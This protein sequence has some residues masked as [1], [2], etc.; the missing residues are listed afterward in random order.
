MIPAEIVRALVDEWLEDFD[1]PEAGYQAMDAN[2]GLTADAWRKRL[3]ETTTIGGYSRVDGEPIWTVGWWARE[4]LDPGDV[5]D[6]LVAM[7]A[8]H[9]WFLPPLHDLEIDWA[10]AKA[11][12][13]PPK[14]KRQR[15]RGFIPPENIYRGGSRPKKPLTAAELVV[16]HRLHQSGLSIKEIARRAYV[17]WGYTSAQGC[18][19]SIGKRLVRAG[20]PRRTRLEGAVLAL[21]THGR[22]RDPEFRREQRRAKGLIQPRCAAT[23]YGAYA[24]WAGTVG[25]PCTRYAMKGSVYCVSHKAL[26]ADAA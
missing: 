2:S 25:Q 26:E 6:L 21:T 1:T 7:D 4:A 13:L 16:V 19:N 20:L 12:S 23:K 24:E 11:S 17:A 9:L 15:R 8:T 5:D 18:A 22:T 14:V 10:S 3:C